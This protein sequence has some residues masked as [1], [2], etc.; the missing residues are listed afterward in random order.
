[1]YNASQDFHNAVA[2]GAKQIALLM[3]DDAV[4]TNDDIDVQRGIEFHDHFCTE[5]DLAIGQALSN[6]I[7]FSLFNDDGWL[8]NYEFGDFTATIGAKTGENIPE[9]EPSPDGTS[10][11][12]IYG[13]PNDAVYNGSMAW[14]GVGVQNA[15]G[16][17]YQWQY[18]SN[19]GRNWGTYSATGST[20]AHVQVPLTQTF[21]ETP[22]LFRCRV[23]KK[24][25]GT[26]TT[27]YTRSVRI[28]RATEYSRV[29]VGGNTFTAY[30]REPYL[31]FNNSFKAEATMPIESLLAYD[32]KVYCLQS[33]PYNPFLKDAVAFNAATGYYESAVYMSE[34]MKAQM[35][36]WAGKGIAYDAQT[37]MM[38]V[39]ADGKHD[40]YEF[41]PLGRFNAERP[42]VPTVNEIEFT[43]YDLMQRFEVDMP[44][45]DNLAAAYESVYSDSYTYPLPF[46]KLFKAMCAYVVVACDATSFT[47]NANATISG[48]PEDFDNAT[49]REVL[50]WLAEAAGSVARFNRNGVLKMDWLRTNTGQSYDEHGYME[51]NPYWY[52]T[53]QVTKLCNRASSGEYESTFGNGDETYLIQDNPLLRGVT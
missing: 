13:Q 17:Q 37:R 49:M 8:N 38:D 45:D 40:R 20:T 52:E 35:S 21:I 14:F 53:K 5:E 7:S 31:R 22:W 48:R 46:V 30:T 4:F 1:M 43:C 12:R 23:Q 27:L 25:N 47:I 39:W 29:T 10:A 41:V 24:I 18:S 51:F 15:E 16:A 28:V 19:G 6:E 26:T 34:V 33:N 32:G 42:N 36:R 44:D 9:D 50:G 3:F 2:N 11:F